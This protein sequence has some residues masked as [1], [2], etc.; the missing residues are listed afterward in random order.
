MMLGF[1][2][3]LPGARGM[4]EKAMEDGILAK[5]DDKIH[6]KTGFLWGATPVVYLHAS[7]A[8][9]GKGY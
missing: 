3:E 2:R 5:R 1:P 8:N 6:G 4:R 9:E 7:T